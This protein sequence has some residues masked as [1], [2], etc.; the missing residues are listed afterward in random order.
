MRIIRD[1]KETHQV[2]LDMIHGAKSEIL[3]IIPSSKAYSREAKLG[4]I[5][6]LEAAAAERH[7]KVLMLTP[8]PFAEE[9]TRKFNDRQIASAKGSEK[10]P[11]LIEYKR[12]L[13]AAYPNTVTVLVIDRTSSLII[14]QQDVS[15][16]DFAKAIGVATYSNR[17]STVKANIRFFERMWEEETLLEKERKSRRE[18]ELLQDIL[19]HD[20]RNYNQIIES[21][22]EMI[23]DP[24]PELNEENRR[25][26]ATEILKTV[27]RS[28]RL[29][30]RAKKLGKIISN[31]RNL[32]HVDLYDSLQRSIEL[33][34]KSNEGKA[35]IHLEFPTGEQKTSVVADDLL[36]EVFVNILSNSITHGKR[37]RI[38]IEIKVE[39]QQG[40][41]A[42]PLNSKEQERVNE[43]WK[44]SF[45]D[46]GSG[47]P[48]EVKGRVFTRYSE[49]S[50]GSGL[51]L[52]IVHALVVDR[53]SGK[54]AIRD[55]VAHEYTQGTVVEILLKQ[56][57]GPS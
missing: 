31:E 15:S 9:E 32:F 29:I 12:I 44:I 22:A 38:P 48:D 2:Y 20:L 43:F 16:L 6:A 56:A 52:S 17:G 49:R 54:V 19:A 37:D 13:E 27:K 35:V 21:N 55:R 53:Y 46:S 47:I 41:E 25:Y 50:S 4:V 57:E 10:I 42:A 5:A 39:K 24:D 33:V 3:L 18:A 45:I 40:N 23:L 28:T 1:P 7:V 14:E 51:G 34:T 36:D 26:H 8:G 11:V 30:D